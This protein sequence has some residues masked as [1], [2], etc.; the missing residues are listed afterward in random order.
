MTFPNLTLIEKYVSRQ[1][2]HDMVKSLDNQI[3]AGLNLEYEMI[4][5]RLYVPDH[6]ATAE[7]NPNIKKP[8]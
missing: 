7:L 1:E 3:N 8:S 4:P 5:N 2:N 6:L